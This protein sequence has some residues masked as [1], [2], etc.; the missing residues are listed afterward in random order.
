MGQIM[1]DLEHYLQK[2]TRGTFGKTRALI[3]NELEANIRLRATELQLLGLNEETAILKA[4]KELGAANLVSRGMTGV[5]TMKTFKKAAIPLSITA[6]LFAA[7]LPFGLA[8]VQAVIPNFGR[9]LNYTSTERAPFLSLNDFKHD[10]E[11]QGVT[12]QDT[13]QAFDQSEV[14]EFENIK[15]PYPKSVRTLSFKFDGSSQTIQIKALP[16]LSVQKNGLTPQF[17]ENENVYVAYYYLLE[18]LKTAHVPITIEGWKNSQLQIG[19]LKLN[20][21]TDSSNVDARTFYGSVLTD[22]YFL[23]ANN[24]PDQLPPSTNY[25]LNEA[26]L[27]YFQHHAIRVNTPAGT[28]FA[29]LSNLHAPGG[30][31]VTGTGEL[32]GY[33]TMHSSFAKVNA[34][35]ILEVYA[36]WNALEFIHKFT[37]LT[38]DYKLLEEVGRNTSKLAQSKLGS[39]SHPAKALLV[40]MTGRL[41]DDAPNIE[42][43]FPMNARSNATK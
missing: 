28:V 9:W 42:L 30:L 18:K 1:T 3:R 31:T 17:I 32:L 35:G 5:Y 7:A 11:K 29:V 33:T 38:P 40:Q 12:V 4:L 13:M 6:A 27:P 14:P 15:V 2:A 34:S 23:E 43:A 22:Q 24:Y 19:Q 36:P 20:L 8:Q 39:S 25:D 16:G 41:D 10:L 21:G 26:T 37:E